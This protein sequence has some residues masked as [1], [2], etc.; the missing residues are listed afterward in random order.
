MHT[1]HHCKTVLG[2]WDY[3][4]ER[5]RAQR[6]ASHGAGTHQ[7]LLRAA[8]VHG[9]VEQHAHGHHD[10]PRTRVGRLVGPDLSKV[11]LSEGAS[12]QRGREAALQAWSSKWIKQREGFRAGVVFE[13][14]APCSRGGRRRC[15]NGSLPFV[16]NGESR[17]GASQKGSKRRAGESRVSGA[18]HLARGVQVTLLCLLQALVDL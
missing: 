3:T 2:L 16:V 9:R 10:Q 13:R 17:E 5:R 11:G 12:L 14:A 7:Q 8:P 6:F 1:A 4:Q 18:S 15:R